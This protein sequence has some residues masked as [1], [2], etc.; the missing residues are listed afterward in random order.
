MNSTEILTIHF[1]PLLDPVW[2]WLGGGFGLALLL[3]VL[4]GRAPGLF[5]RSLSLALLVLALANPVAEHATVQPVKDSA[6]LVVD[7][8]A[9]DKLP[10]RQERIA[11]ALPGLRA[12]L[13]KFDDLDWREIHVRGRHASLPGAA[14]LEETAVTPPERRGGVILL[15]DGQAH[16][17][18]A[19]M[20]QLT[21]LGPVHTLLTGQHDEQDRR[22]ELISV[23]HYGLVGKSVTLKFR[24]LDQPARAPEPVLLFLNTLNGP[25][26]ELR[27]HTG[28]EATYELPIT[29]A[30][31][32]VF[33]LI[34]DTPP[35][36][37]APTN[38]RTI[39]KVTGVREK[40]RVLLVSGE[41][42]PGERAW[43]N[44]LKAD[45]A[46]E[47][48]HFTILRPPLKQDNTP[49]TQLALIAFPIRELFEEKLRSFDLV[50][51]DRFR[52]QGMLPMPY[53]NNI[54][55][56]VEDG[57]AF[58][59]ASGPSYVTP[60]SLYQTPLARILPAAPKNRLIAQSFVPKPTAEGADHPVTRDLGDPEQWA[61]WYRQTQTET[62]RGDVLLTGAGDL[63]LLIL[64]RV[65][66]G[67]V[68]QLTSD[69]IWLWQRGHDK[70]GPYAELMRRIVHW[71]MQEP[72]LEE[73]LLRLSAAEQDDGYVLTIIRPG[74][75]PADDR[76]TLTDPAG[77][78]QTVAL[79]PN[80]AQRR[81]E[82]TVNVTTTGVY[83][84]KHDS[85]EQIISIGDPNAKELQDLRTT[86][87]I[88]A[89]LADATGGGIFWLTDHPDN[90][91]IE[92]SS[93]SGRQYGSDWLGLRRNGQTATLG[94]RAADIIPAWAWVLLITATVMLG[95][96]REGK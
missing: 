24:I 49:I 25:I 80:P 39:V 54:A 15:T 65:G 32:N 19:L 33:T 13:Q 27:L 45:P 93:K 31:D 9:S 43:R 36:D 82:A 16:D 22:I 23:P 88:L 14:M 40:L 83:T 92:R 28:E 21:Q 44:L 5:W 94:T 73:G 2:L 4:R 10:G 42:H 1:A 85:K 89:P 11:A 56:Y 87:A 60:Q 86:D 41:P 8:T 95:W 67:R 46:V 79:T 57:G 72:E 35:K 68:A 52:K 81:A 53:L 71:T 55:R 26:Q 96:R 38:N 6:L 64:D 20:P 47:L 30:G 58:I 66:K 61:S 18:A 62:Q 59:D 48:V 51:F 70:G 50:I 63:P 75:T 76:V 74:T 91:K 37:I 84:V 90:L 12:Q 29:H 7:D 78:T 3:L 34:I 77:Q 17:I 69:Q